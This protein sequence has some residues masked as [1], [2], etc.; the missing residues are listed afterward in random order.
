M[1]KHLKRRLRSCN[2]PIMG[3]SGLPE[4]HI[5]RHRSATN[6]CAAAEPKAAQAFG[7]VE[8]GGGAADDKHGARSA[9][10]RVLKHPRQLGV[11]AQGRAAPCADVAGSAGQGAACARLGAGPQPGSP[12]GYVRL[13]AWVCQGVDH[14]AQG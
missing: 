5:P 2:L 14:V 8:E 10:Q 3:S 11:A 6:L 4:Q 7:I 13:A 12:E 1:L 9:A